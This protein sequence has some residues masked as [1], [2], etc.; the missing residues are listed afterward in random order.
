MA[1]YQSFRGRALAL[2]GLLT[3][4]IEILLVVAFLQKYSSVSVGEFS[5][6]DKAQNFLTW[7]VV[8]FW[9]LASIAVTIYPKGIR[10]YQNRVF[11]LLIGFM[12]LLPAWL[13]ANLLHAISP[14]WL[15]YPIVL[16]C[17]ADAAAAKSLNSQ[18]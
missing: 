9:V 8:A 16:V 18:F 6:F 12:V 2:L 17:V 4:P 3:M 15:I 14:R 7:S 1:G 13:Y 5:Y 11:N 10:F